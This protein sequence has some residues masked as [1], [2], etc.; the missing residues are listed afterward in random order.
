MV[1]QHKTIVRRML[2]EVWNGGNLAVVDEIVATD[3]VGH[4]P[5]YPQPIRGPEGFKQWVMTARMAFPD[6]HI[7]VEDLL[8]EGDR[9]VGRITMRGTHNGELAGLPPTGQSV[10][11]SGIF[12]RRLEGD[13]F[14]EGWDM[15]DMLGLLRQLGVI[16]AAGQA[17][18]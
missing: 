13:K 18:A 14:I 15:A 9:V 3:Y 8:A 5:S 2:E 1:E 11:F 17:G 6:F 12:V 4:D 10:E 7:T 16:P